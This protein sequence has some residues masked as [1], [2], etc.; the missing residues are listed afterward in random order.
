MINNNV[1]FL[2]LGIDTFFSN[3]VTVSQ[4]PE[5]LHFYDHQFSL[6]VA[7]WSSL[8]LVVCLV[9]MEMGIEI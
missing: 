6:Q 7:L 3:L 4:S 2:F 9:D 5:L 8:L 1:S